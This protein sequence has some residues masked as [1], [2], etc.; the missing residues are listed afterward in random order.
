[1]SIILKGERKNN[2]FNYAKYISNRKKE[3][4]AEKTHE[5]SLENLLFLYE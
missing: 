3:K 2:K 4:R 1:M 5:L